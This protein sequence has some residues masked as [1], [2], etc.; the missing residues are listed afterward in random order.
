MSSALRSLLVGL[1]TAIAVVG[2]VLIA[3]PS[4][5][6]HTLAVLALAA[7]LAMALG[8]LLASRRPWSM[9]TKLSAAAWI[10][11][12]VLVG[13]QLD[14]TVHRLGLAIGL[15]VL[16]DGLV[17]LYGAVASPADDKF[18][19]TLFGVAGS[20]LGALLLIWSDATVLSVGGLFG[21]RVLWFGAYV[22]W[23][24]V[25]GTYDENEPFQPGSMR[26]IRT[27]SAAATALFVAVAGASVSYELH[28]DKATAPGVVKIPEKVPSQPGKLISAEA[29]TLDVPAG[30]QA[31]RILYTTTRDKG[32]PAVST[33]LV[34]VKKDR[35][36]SPRPVI[37]WAHGTTGIATDCAPSLAGDAVRFSSI[38]GLDQ[39]LD[40][41]WAFV[42]TD[43]IGLGT[44]GPHPYLIGQG[45]GRSVLDAVRAARE[46]KDLSLQ[47]KTVIWGH[48]QGGNAALWAGVLA[49]TY[50]P[51]LDVLGVAGIAP[52]TDLPGLVEN[53]TKIPTG[54][55]FGAYVISAYSEAYPDVKY[56]SYVTPLARQPMRTAATLC[57][58]E[59][60]RLAALA[61][62][63]DFT[64]KLY[65]Q[66]PRTGPL[67][68]RLRE[69][70]P[71]GTLR[72]PTL[73][74]QGTVDPLV[75]PSLQTAYV[76]QRC[77]QSGNGPLDYRT[78]DGRN[79][80][81]IVAPGSAMIPD[82][83]T[84]TEDRFAGKTAVSTC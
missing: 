1:G 56:D 58:E 18:L 80:T 29:F 15:I 37:A 81:D 28:Q 82:L 10:G 38:P 2:A 11:G 47:K 20:A 24:G 79:H 65:A 36:D 57:I 83:L 5:A 34:V 3:R 67:D 69:N 21:T 48:S 51:D 59:T 32:V 19:I 74:A 40:D 27:A 70:S 43:Y 16:L 25:R 8:Q 72:M 84:W 41:G 7:F 17:N 53:I 76:A 66:D 55:L 14:G 9:A 60:S 61:K 45:E 33:A 77:G 31:W 52:A 39:A 62:D 26:R 22:G 75:L 4:D 6:R 46:V 73:I 64:Q 54:A 44:P 35:P 71:T 42:A 63:F 50:T 12:A 13:A 23:A 78:Y 49:P 30:A 68:Q